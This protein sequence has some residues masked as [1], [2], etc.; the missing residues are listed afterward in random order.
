MTIGERIRERRNEI[1]LTLAQLAKLV[2]VSEATMSRCENGEI[3]KFQPERINKIAQVLGTSS[4]WLLGE[5]EDQPT[6]AVSVELSQT[7][8]LLLK[9]YRDFTPEEKNTVRS[10]ILAIN[11]LRCHVH[12]TERALAFAEEFIDGTEYASDYR[13]EK[14][15][16]SSDE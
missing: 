3:T 6:G 11:A 4:A 13:K 15:S 1:K 12:D 10:V 14:D 7:E 8:N 2:G 16:A 9:I 5:R